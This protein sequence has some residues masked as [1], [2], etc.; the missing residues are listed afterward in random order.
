VSLGKR[1][2]PSYDEDIDKELLKEKQIDGQEHE[3]GVVFGQEGEG[4]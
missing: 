2:R 1:S 4:K 3:Q